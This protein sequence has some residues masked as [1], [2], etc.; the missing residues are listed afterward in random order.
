MRIL[1]VAVV[2]LIL[3]IGARAVLAQGYVDAPVATTNSTASAGKY[4]VIGIKLGMSSHQASE[5]LKAH[6]PPLQFKPDTVKY[7]ILPG[8]MAYGVFAANQAAFV[9]GGNIG[10]QNSERIYLLMS[11]PPAKEQVVTNVIRMVVFSKET[12]PTADNL[13][14]DLVKKYGPLS[15]DSHPADLMTSGYRDLW[16]V[17]DLQGNRM[18][19]LDANS[20]VRSC[21]DMVTFNSNILSGYS[22]GDIRPDQTRIKTRLEQ[23]FD[24]DPRAKVCGDHTIVHAHLYYSWVISIKSS[25]LVGALGVSIGSVPLD[26]SST[27]ATRNMLMQAA[28]NHDVQQKKA[29]AQNKPVL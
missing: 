24:A 25:D 22:L 12:A 21:N 5:I 28:Q 2:F 6:K 17:D 13:V 4:D 10:A 20:F 26:R 3:T 29:A 18:L 15:Y 1:K 19:N 23:G 14:A 9:Q 27:E 8:P 11:M 7:D 16:W